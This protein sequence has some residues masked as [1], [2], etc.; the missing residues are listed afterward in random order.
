[1]C[2]VNRC[3]GWLPIVVSGPDSA[4]MSILSKWRYGMRASAKSLLS[5][6]ALVLMIAAVTHSALASPTNDK[7]NVDKQLSQ[8]QATM[9]FATK[10]AQ[11]AVAAYNSANQQ[12]PG[13]Q[14]AVS[15][16]QGEVIAAQVQA[17]EAQRK[18]D[19][20]QKQLDA[21]Q[22][23][24]HKAEEGVQGERTVF[25]QF[26]QKSYEGGYYLTAA[27]VLAVEGP[28]QLVAALE[29]LD[30]LAAERR[31]AVRVMKSARIEVAEK[32][33]TVTGHKREVDKANEQAKAAVQTAE[34]EQANAAAAQQHVES[35]IGQRE[36]AVTVA[37]QERASSET[38]YEQLQQESERLAAELRAQQ[39]KL[40]NS[41]HNNNTGAPPPQATGR[42]RKPVNGYKSSD[43]GSRYDPYYKR[44]QLHAGTDFAAPGGAPIWA[45]ADGIVVRTGWNGGYGNYTCI[46]HG[47]TEYNGRTV[48]LST[49]Y[50]HQSEIDV[51]NGE[52]VESGEVIGRVGTTG[53]S[54]GNHL[55]FEVRL[56]GTP[57]NPL[58][59][60]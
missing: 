2:R 23:V 17:R 7:Q 9:E 52:H 55:H 22:A 16:A 13:A 41:N 53:A 49:C 60:L 27:A 30:T 44:W 4:V 12:L 36:Q 1:M 25:D 45:A 34:T 32:R 43:F 33:A 39:N 24:Y 29:Y 48:G 3:V 21:A 10:K 58:N 51:S 37:E 26:V 57:V 59:W 14:Q 54:T 31:D 56:D 35:L 19:E 38:Q 47:E 28:E 11:E 46:Y 42:F 18:A 50:A 20:A 40:K 6:I 15:E 5:G 8:A